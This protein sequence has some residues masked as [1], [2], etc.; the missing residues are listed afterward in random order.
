[1]RNFLFPTALKMMMK[2][3]GTARR[4]DLALRS[5]MSAGEAV[6][7]T[8]FTWAQRRLVTINEMFGQ[9]EMNPHRRQF[10]HALAREAGLDGAAVP[11][12]SHLGHRR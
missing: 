7:T 5:V 10:A 9:T 3:A 1:V 11:R 8:V 6:G 12:S 4:F 2:A